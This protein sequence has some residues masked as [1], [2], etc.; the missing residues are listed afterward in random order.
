[1]A[2]EGA[3]FDRRWLSMMILHHQGA[4]EMAKAQLAGGADPGA[5]NL[6]QR[7]IDAQ[8]AEIGEMQ[9]LLPQG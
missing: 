7:I 2:A 6:A 4:V 3:D 1:M 5:R 8:E 9:A